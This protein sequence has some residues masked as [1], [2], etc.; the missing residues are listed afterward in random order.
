MLGVGTELEY[1]GHPPLQHCGMQEDA[2]LCWIC[3]DI[4]GELIYPCKCPRTAHKR[5]LAR[6]QLQSAGTRRETH[7]E[8]CDTALPDWKKALTPAPA[9]AEKPPAIMNVNFDGRTYSFEVE[10]GPNGYAKFTEAI[11][12][13]F[14]LPDDS[15]LNIT[16][17]CDEPT[18]PELG[19]LLT[20]Q[21]AGAYDAAVHC[22][23][24][25]AARRATCPGGTDHHHSQH[26]PIR[27]SSL[28]VNFD[29]DMR[30]E[31]IEEPEGVEYASYDDSRPC[32]FYQ[33]A[34]PEQ[35]LQR[36]VSMPGGMQQQDRPTSVDIRDNTASPPSAS[37]RRLSGLSRKVRSLLD[38]LGH[39][40]RP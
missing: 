8:F 19:S 5:C 2:P 16:F 17:T 22:A 24:L 38:M 1:T 35:P 32:G 20:L 12:R 30:S 7:C 26:G 10:P 40:A 3:L 13:A 6:W 15:E 14:D 25:S 29:R 31:G 21:G 18:V 34:T 4:G 11:R 9:V 33:P 28:P 27:T 23:A 39:P 37:K 36:H